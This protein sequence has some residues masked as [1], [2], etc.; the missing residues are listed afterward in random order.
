MSSAWVD[1]KAVKQAVSIDMAIAYYGLMVRRIHG[2][3]LR[4]RCP[5][6]SHTSKSSTQSFISNTVPTKKTT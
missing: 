4:G 3:Y 2:P 1:Y 6:P 5:L